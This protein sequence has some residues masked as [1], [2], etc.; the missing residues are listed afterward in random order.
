VGV[1]E[2]ARTFVGVAVAASA[3]V[4]TVTMATSAQAVPAMIFFNM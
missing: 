4:T 2:A 3:G 1:A